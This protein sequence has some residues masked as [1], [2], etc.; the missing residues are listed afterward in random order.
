MS[1][2]TTD[3]M[4]DEA[5]KKLRKA[6]GGSLTVASI[7]AADESIMHEAIRKGGLADKKIK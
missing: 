6:V 2:A 4:C 1:T 5:V 3:I 7:L